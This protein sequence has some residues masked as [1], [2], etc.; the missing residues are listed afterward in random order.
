MT[1]TTHPVRGRPWARRLSVC[2]SAAWCLAT[3]MPSQAAEWRVLPAGDPAHAGLMLRAWWSE[4]D[5][6]ANPV[7]ARGEETSRRPVVVLLHGCGGMLGKDGQPSARMNTYAR[8]LNAQGWHTL[9]VDSLTPRGETELCTQRNGTRKITMTQRRVDALA[10]LQWL[11]NQPGVDPQRLALLGWSNGG[12]A[13]LAST[14]LQHPDVVKARAQL[15][16]MGGALKLTVA[17]Y[18]GC[19]AEARRGYQPWSPTLL[20]LGLADDWTPARQCL[21]LGSNPQVHIHTWEGAHHG[22]D[23][24][25]PVVHRKDVPNGAHPGEGVHV[26]GHP[27]A[28]QESQDALLKALT[29]AFGQSP[30]Q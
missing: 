22:F 19:A 25:G 2:L 9:A 17:F 7:P 23:G 16:Q 27:V 12:S 1:M 30:S 3:A 13:L 11:A 21:P 24:S 15:T 4:A 18:P 8:L 26:G 28:R 5:F 20:L 14:N 6:S 29:E 10:A